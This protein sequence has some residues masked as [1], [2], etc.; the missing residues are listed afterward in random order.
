MASGYMQMANYIHPIAL[1]QPDDATVGVASS[2]GQT[3]GGY[4]AKGYMQI[5]NYS[6]LIALVQPDNTTVGVARRFGQ[7]AGGYTE[8]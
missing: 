2:F 3:A 8:F 4:M 6:H 1:V 5:A 7:T